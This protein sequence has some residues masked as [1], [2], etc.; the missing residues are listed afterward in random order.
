ML[1]IAAEGLMPRLVA[2]VQAS[3]NA[4][5]ACQRLAPVAASATQKYLS[6]SQATLKKYTVKDHYEFDQ[7]VSV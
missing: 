7:K 1:K 3:S 4:Q 2:C 5:S 6:Q